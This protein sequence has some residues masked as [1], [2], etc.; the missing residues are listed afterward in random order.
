M[1]ILIVDDRHLSEV[2]VPSER[3]MAQLHVQMEIIGQLEAQV[4]LPDT[5]IRATTGE[6]LMLV[7]CICDFVCYEDCLLTSLLMTTKL[8]S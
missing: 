1:N 3:G 2:H 4:C 6:V 5:L 7:A 8:S